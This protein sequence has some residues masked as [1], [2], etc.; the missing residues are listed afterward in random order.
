MLL[1]LKYGH[2]QSKSFNIDCI[3]GNL[4]D[5]AKQEAV[6]ETVRTLK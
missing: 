4:L 2:K 1:L 3:L 6:T 5:T